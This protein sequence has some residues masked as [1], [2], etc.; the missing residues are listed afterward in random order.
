M[1]LSGARDRHDPGLLGQQPGNRDL[2]GCRL[3][4]CRNAAEQINKSLVRLARFCGN[5]RDDVA[6]VSAIERGVLVDLSGEKS[7]AKR[8]KRN[9]PDS[10]F[11]ECRRSE[12]HTSELQ[13]HR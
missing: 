6:K 4:L 12:E 9:E 8:A 1:R 10:E 5:T 13:S 3:L 7:S 11:L 2:R